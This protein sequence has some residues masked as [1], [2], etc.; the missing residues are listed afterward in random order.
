[1]SHRFLTSIGAIAV[2]GAVVI[3]STTEV[4]GQ[5][6]GND[7]AS[8]AETKTWKPARTAWG[9]P[10]LTGI[11]SNSDESGI[12]LE[13]PAQFEGRRLEDITAKEL[14]ELRVARRNATAANS[15]AEDRPVDREVFWENLNAV[16]SR[17][18]LIV[19]PPDGT[20]AAS[21]AR[22]V[23]ERRDLITA[24]CSVE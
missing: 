21:A 2:L 4:A 10:D 6:Q 24:N 3:L 13:R 12:P 15:V 5:S 17:A 22:T 9:D 16:N 14:E 7:G 8:R 19:D 11:Y 1:M 20:R 18:W 23:P